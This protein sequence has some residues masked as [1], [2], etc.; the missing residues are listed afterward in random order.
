MAQDESSIGDSVL[1][2]A[3]FKVPPYHALDTE[4]LESDIIVDN[5]NIDLMGELCMRW[6]FSRPE[7]LSSLGIQIGVSPLQT[8]SGCTDTAPTRNFYLFE[9]EQDFSAIIDNDNGITD[10]TN[11]WTVHQQD[12]PA[13]EPL[14]PY[15]HG[16]PFVQ[17]HLCVQS[18]V[19]TLS[20][21]ELQAG[22]YALLDDLC[23][24]WDYSR[25]EMLGAKGVFIGVSPL[26]T[27][28][29]CADTAPT[30][31]F[32]VFGPESHAGPEPGMDP[33]GQAPGKQPPCSSRRISDEPSPAAR[34]QT[35]AAE[36]A[37]DDEGSGASL[38]HTG[39][40]A[41]AD[42]PEL[43]DAASEITFAL[44]RRPPQ[45]RPLPTLRTCG[46]LE[47]LR[48]GQHLVPEFAAL[49]VGGGGVV[50]PRPRL[51]AA[52]AGRPAPARPARTNGWGM[53]LSAAGEGG[54]AGLAVDSLVP[55][56][57]AHL[58]GLV[59]RG[60]VITQ[61]DGVD[62]RGWGVRQVAILMAAAAGDELRLTVRRLPP[63]T[64]DF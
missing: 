2:Q 47:L 53:L 51:R 21:E 8:W 23:S 7:R 61:V 45:Q 41:P 39:A 14:E 42:G 6:D 9:Q 29:G 24:R 43:L 1:S 18:A 25:P 57:P 55:G 17:D 54:A 13:T 5:N 36:R 37:E 58:S 16:K 3:G 46:A 12:R 48:E 26:H 59:R 44:T 63:R 64:Y 38:P 49:A 50:E 22:I 11:G 32:Y 56:G 31:S 52:P 35:P 28:S 62:V 27:W 20:Q 10:C 30:R 40:A 33:P 60:D 34:R 4:I 15:N 19:P